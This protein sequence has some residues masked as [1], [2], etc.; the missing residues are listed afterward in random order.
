MVKNAGPDAQAAEKTRKTLQTI[1]DDATAP[2]AARVQAA[3]TL[4]EMDGRIGRLQRTADGPRPVRDL[5]RAELEAELVAL[6]AAKANVK[7][8]F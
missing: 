7:L 3:R 5:T 2:A 6:R 1:A 8:P 4:A